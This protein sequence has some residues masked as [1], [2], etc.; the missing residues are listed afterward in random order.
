MLS[1]QEEVAITRAQKQAGKQSGYTK[2]PTSLRLDGIIYSHPKAW[3]IWLNGRSIKAGES[4]ESIR[5]LKVTP[6]S[7]DL[8][9]SPKPDQHHRICLKLNDVFQSTNSFP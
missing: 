1:P 9:W 2:S 8:V 5:I 7:V 4:V 6:Q 3:A